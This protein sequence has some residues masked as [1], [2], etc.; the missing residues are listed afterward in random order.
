[1]SQGLEGDATV[2]MFLAQFS[3]GLANEESTEA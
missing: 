2:N 1:M 3:S